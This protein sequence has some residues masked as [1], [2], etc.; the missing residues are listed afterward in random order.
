M[1]I[2]HYVLLF[3]DYKIGVR[4]L[5]LVETSI[6]R[7]AILTWND[8]RFSVVDGKI[9]LKARKVVISDHQVYLPTHHYSLP[10]SRNNR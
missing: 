1:S 3:Y 4:Y 9:D 8:S 6:S 7:Y 10:L 5:S 2:F